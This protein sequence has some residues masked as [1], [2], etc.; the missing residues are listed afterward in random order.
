[1][2]ITDKRSIH[3]GK[4][5]YECD[6]CGR[7]SPWET[8]WIW[9]GSIRDLDE[10]P[11]KVVVFCSVDCLEEKRRCQFENS[12]PPLPAFEVSHG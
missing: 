8:G 1:M 5:L 6:Q 7:L 3:T 11:E 12:W 9:Y 2:S 4:R 10:T